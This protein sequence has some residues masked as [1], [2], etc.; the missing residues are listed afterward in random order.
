M[1]NVHSCIHSSNTLFSCEFEPVISCSSFR[2]A[3]DRRDLKQ[4][5]FWARTDPLFVYLC[6][7]AHSYGIFVENLVSTQTWER[8]SRFVTDVIELATS[9]T[10]VVHDGKSRVVDDSQ[11]EDAVY[12]LAALIVPAFILD[13]NQLSPAWTVHNGSEVVCNLLLLDVVTRKRGLILN[14]LMSILDRKHQQ[15]LQQFLWKVSLTTPNVPIDSIPSISLMLL[16][17]NHFQGSIEDVLTL[18]P[19]RKDVF[20]VVI[21]TFSQ[22]AASLEKTVMASDQIGDLFQGKVASALVDK[23]ENVSELLLLASSCIGLSHPEYTKFL[24]KVCSF[25]KNVEVIK[26]QS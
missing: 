21:E 2:D 3:I 12:T 22:H 24:R 4:L 25:L 19:L 10:G 1:S 8:L 17:F 13:H 6:S 11:E 5:G 15:F 16:S 20:D 14:S 7:F 18:F 9:E 23:Q 26:E